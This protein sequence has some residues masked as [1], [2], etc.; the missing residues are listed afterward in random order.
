MSQENTEQSRD[1]VIVRTSILGIVAN[2]FLA[3]FKAIVGVLSNSIAI[4][5]DAVNN[6][7]DAMSSVITIAGT[8]LA[9]RKPD[10]KHPLGYGR[11]E[12]LSATII[13]VIVLY[14]G[15]TSFVESVK[16]ILSPEKADYSTVTLVIVAA[17]V[18]VKI[19][20][21]RYVK[22]V[23]EKVNSDAL[24]ASGTDA[25]LDS[26][27]SA[28]TLVAA[29]IY[30]TLGISLE[31][32]LGAIISIVIIK[33]GI[34]ML[35]DTVSQILGERADAS[36][37]KAI[38]AT[39]ASFPEVNGA[40]DLLLHAYGP[41]TYVGSVHIEIPDTMTAGEIDRLTRNIRREVYKKHKVM[42]EGVSVYS[43]NTKDDN[44]H[45]MMETCRNIVMSHEY[46]LQMHGFYV[47]EETKNI[48]FDMVLSFKANNK[49]EIFKEVSD[50]IRKVYPDYTLTI[51]LDTD[52]SD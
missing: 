44:A 6:L 32:W 18:V 42:L 8:K 35:R 23:G 43:I 17:A 37:T 38:K 7:S 16:K 3:T 39:I 27:I 14:A 50:R 51:A 41:D 21:G 24:I 12:Y 30:M 1:S 10:R 28:S 2:V 13:S 52:F 4:V 36:F 22:S 26:I 40:Y 34:E 20:L 47:D 33:S 19:L 25:T 48:S 5:L 49:D 9:G 29:A 45:A 15:V 11:L 46:V 31:A